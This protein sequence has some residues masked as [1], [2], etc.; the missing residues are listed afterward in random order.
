MHTDEE[1]TRPPASISRWADP[2]ILSAAVIVA[3]AGLARLA[4]SDRMLAILIVATT[5]AVMGTVEWLRAPRSAA[6][7]PL[8][9]SLRN[10]AITWVGTMAGLVLLL[11]AW[12]A[13]P[14]YESQY[15]APFF[16]T[17][18]LILVLAPFVSAVFAFVAIRTFGPATAGD[19]QLGL[20]ALG[21]FE[22]IDWRSV[23]DAVIIW[24]IRG[25]FLPINFVELART[26]GAFRGREFSLLS[27]G[28]VPGEYYLLLMLYALII[29]AVTP[30]YL[31]GSRR[32]RTQTTLVSHSW[33]AW[34]VTLACYSPFETAFFV[35]WFDYN[36][37]SP[38]PAWLEPWAAHLSVVPVALA[39][40]GA[41]I[42]LLTLVHLWGEAQ[43]GLRSSNMSDRGI[44]TAGPYRFTK[45]PVYAAKC[46]AWLLIWMPFAS[47]AGLV[48]DLRLTVLWAGVCVIYGLRALAEEQLLAA[49]PV[50]VAYARWI[51]RH[52]AFWLLGRI[53]PPLSFE[54]RLA[55]WRA[56]P[57]L[58]VEQQGTGAVLAS[59]P[60]MAAL[61]GAERAP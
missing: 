38:N 18:P 26:I 32:I 1:P 57:A 34:A 45:H 42:L 49:D 22:R 28:W 48:D 5:I 14:E 25:F 17:L 58:S 16:E 39:A 33:F 27:G 50:Y 21:Q 2:F 20:L 11:L 23:R 36:P 30:G 37:V 60:D 55:Y 46:A 12:G 53:F 35:N 8:R 44:I 15:Y 56:H 3:Y 4:I 31:F 9:Q 24:L 7:Y 43:F 52:G 61:R 40:V 51:D 59:Y 54:W 29:A 10:A 47:G 13:L 6:P 19:Y 41:A